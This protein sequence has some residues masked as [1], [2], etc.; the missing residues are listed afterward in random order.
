[1]ADLTN[2]LNEWAAYTDIIHRAEVSRHS[3]EQEITDQ[4]HATRAEFA[5]APGVEATL[6]GSVEY[7]KALDGP[8]ATMAEQLSPDEL[9]AVL[10]KPKPAPAR[11]FNITAVKKL[12]KQGGIY[13][14]ALDKASRDVAPVLRVRSV[15]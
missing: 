1:M 3:I 12:A 15:E 14:D 8:L 2:L 9:D 13:R 5:E 10:T 4:M 6:K 7:D 11:S